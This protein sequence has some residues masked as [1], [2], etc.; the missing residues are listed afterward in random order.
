MKVKNTNIYYHLPSLYNKNNKYYIISHTWRYQQSIACETISLV[1]E[2]ILQRSRPLQT[3]A[4]YLSMSL[5]GRILLC[6]SRNTY[7]WSI[8]F[9]IRNFVPMPYL[10]FWNCIYKW[11]YRSSIIYIYIYIYMYTYRNKHK[12]AKIY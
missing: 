9:D 1:F 2:M 12:N 6:L 3:M 11:T 4:N 8:G 5:A 7:P 10:I